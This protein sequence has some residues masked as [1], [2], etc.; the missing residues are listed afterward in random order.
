MKLYSLCFKLFESF[1]FSDDETRVKLE[2]P[3][4][5]SSDYINANYIDGYCKQK[6]YIATQGP[7]KNTIDD[8]WLLCWEQNVQV[9]V[10]V[11][12][13]EERGRVSPFL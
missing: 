4:Y 8:F 2:S 11:T 6:A 12:K 10:M 5:N 3:S 7:M 13:L 9:I 1:S